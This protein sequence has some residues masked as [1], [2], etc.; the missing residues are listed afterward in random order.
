[1]PW[2]KGPRDGEEYEH[3]DKHFRIKRRQWI[4]TVSVNGQDTNYSLDLVPRRNRDQTFP[5]IWFTWPEKD[6]VYSKV[7]ESLDDLKAMLDKL[8]IKERPRYRQTYIEMHD[9]LARYIG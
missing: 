6:S 7:F 5:D 4:Y 1:M 3:V 2:K 8:G 9:V